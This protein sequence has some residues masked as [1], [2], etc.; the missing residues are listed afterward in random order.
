MVGALLTVL[1]LGV[2]QLGLA[3]LVRNTVIDAAAEGARFGALADNSPQDG[4]ART[5][6]LI[7]TALGGR[8]AQDVTAATGSYLGQPALIVTVRAPLPLVGLLGP[9][10]LEVSGHAAVETLR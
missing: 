10:A 2:I 1:T 7:T 5:A 8:Y 9:T 4:V 6:D 3:L